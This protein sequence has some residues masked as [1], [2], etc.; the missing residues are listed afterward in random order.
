MVLLKMLPVWAFCYLISIPSKVPDRF[1]LDEKCRFYWPLLSSS[2]VLGWCPLFVANHAKNPSGHRAWIAVRK[3]SFRKTVLQKTKK[4][5]LWLSRR[6]KFVSPYRQVGCDERS[7]IF[8]ERKLILLDPETE[9]GTLN[10]LLHLLFWKGSKVKS[11][12][13]LKRLI[14][15]LYFT[16]TREPRENVS[17]QMIDLGKGVGFPRMIRRPRPRISYRIPLFI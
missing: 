12:Y 15:S 13:Q 4:G 5:E 3:K 1:L 10:C 7:V 6:R 9:Q 8:F 16:L 17:G 2:L 11:P 14:S